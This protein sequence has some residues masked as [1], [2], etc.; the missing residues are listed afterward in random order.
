MITRELVRK[1]RDAASFGNVAVREDGSMTAVRADY[2]AAARRP[3]VVLR[4]MRPLNEFAHLD[5]ALDDEELLA[6][7][8]AEVGGGS[9]GDRAGL[10]PQRISGQTTSP[11]P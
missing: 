7:I 10:M 8:E 5:V 1:L 4:P 3:L 2:S 11:S 9:R 6:A